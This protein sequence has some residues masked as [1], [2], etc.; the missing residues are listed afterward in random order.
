MTCLIHNDTLIK[1]NLS[2][3]KIFF[4]IEESVE[5]YFIPSLYDCLKCLNA[6]V[7]C[8][9]KPQLN[10]VNFQQKQFKYLTNTFLETVVN[11]T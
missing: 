9:E 1:I 2:N 11:R 10:I 8:I 5:I 3:E 6:H 7:T 4:F